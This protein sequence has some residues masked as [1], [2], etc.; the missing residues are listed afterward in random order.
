MTVRSEDEIEIAD[1]FCG[2]GGSSS[3]AV[4]AC[5]ERGLKVTLTAVNHSERAIQTHWANFP[6]AEHVRQDIRALQPRKI[7]RS[8]HVDVLVASPECRAYSPARGRK[9]WK[10]QFRTSPREILRW[11][12]DLNVPNVIV[13][14][15]PDFLD[16]GP[17]D[18]EGYPVPA[19]RGIFYK[20]FI[21][22]LIDQGY[23]VDDRVLTAADYGDATTR[24][25]LFIQAR[26]G[27]PISWPEPSHIPERWRPARDIID[28]SLKGESIFSRKQPLAENTLG[29]IVSGLEKF[30]GEAF[31]PFLELYYGTKDV[32]TLMRSLRTIKAYGPGEFVLG[33]ESD[34][35]PW[36][37]SGPISTTPRSGANSLIRAFIVKYYGTGAAVSVD[38]PLDTITTKD[39]FGLVT[40]CPGKHFGIDILFRMLAPHELA[41]AMSFRKGYI[42][43]G[44]HAEQ[45]QQIGNAVPV[46]LARALVGEILD[47]YEPALRRRAA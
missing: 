28:W 23:T 25:R 40:T 10:P 44:T 41:A 5:D 38:D 11:T 9:A 39:R 12:G 26:R 27:S 29:R 7:I 42:F 30:G 14:N 32:R 34:V 21:A 45:V 1:L 36:R 15:V 16:W 31:K 22:A 18:E 4:E 37:I 24:Q 2:G 47:T 17:L 43:S 46:K 33:Q 13:E 19:F 20:R 35:E 8:G 3:G 6:W